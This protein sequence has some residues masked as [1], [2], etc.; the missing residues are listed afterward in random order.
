LF[1]ARS[2]VRLLKID[3]SFRFRDNGAGGEAKGVGGGAQK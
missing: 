2:A 3:E 1:A